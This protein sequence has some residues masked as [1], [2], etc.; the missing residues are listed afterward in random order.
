MG[1]KGDFV[2]MPLKVEL[3][4]LAGDCEKCGEYEWLFERNG[5]YYCG[6]CLQAKELADEGGQLPLIQQKG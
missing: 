1:E 5:H 2:E 6:M 3:S 4:N